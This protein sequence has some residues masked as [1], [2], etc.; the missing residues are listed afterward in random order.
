MAVSGHQL[1]AKPPGRTGEEAACVDF[2]L[3]TADFIL[4]EI[5]LR[6]CLLR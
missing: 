4:K 6:T 5:Q 1:Y 2:F 3:H